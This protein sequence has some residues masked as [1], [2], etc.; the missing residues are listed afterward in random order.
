[1]DKY[2]GH[3]DMFVA[4]SDSIFLLPKDTFWAQ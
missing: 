2:C 1:M 3:F 4:I